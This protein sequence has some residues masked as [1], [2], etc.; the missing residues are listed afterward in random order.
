M[1]ALARKGFDMIIGTTF[2]YGPTMASLA[3]E[4]PKISG[5]HISGYQSNGKTMAICSAG[6]KI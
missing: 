2:E 1:T 4:F 6:W 3:Q 5:L